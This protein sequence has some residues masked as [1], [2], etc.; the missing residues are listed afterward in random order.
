L[1]DNPILIAVAVLVVAL[2]TAGAINSLRALRTARGAAE[3][4]LLIVCL[5]G[6]L[7]P[8]FGQVAIYGEVPGAVLTKAVQLGY[9]SVLVTGVVLAVKH[10]RRIGQK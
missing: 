7:L 4:L 8:L 5:A 1:N 6:I 2:F 10:L 3:Y 9:I